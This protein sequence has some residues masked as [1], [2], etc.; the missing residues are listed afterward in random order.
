MQGEIIPDG[1]RDVEVVAWLL[2]RFPAANACAVES[3]IVTAKDRITLILDLRD[4]FRPSMFAAS[5]VPVDFIPRLRSALL[6]AAQPTSGGA[7]PAGS[8]G[9]PGETP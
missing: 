2:E 5:G 1:E 9:T 4:S 7:A 8:S 6:A 3:A